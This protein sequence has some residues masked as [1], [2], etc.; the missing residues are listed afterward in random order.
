MRKAHVLVAADY[1]A[2]QCGGDDGLLALQLVD[3]AYK[4]LLP[5]RLHRRHGYPRRKHRPGLVLRLYNTRL[6]NHPARQLGRIANEKGGEN[7]LIVTLGYQLLNIASNTYRAV[8]EL[9]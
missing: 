4:V 9:V 6:P 5:A 3:R 2:V 7:Q 8:N 1:L